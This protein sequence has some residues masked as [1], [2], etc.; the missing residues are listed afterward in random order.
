LWSRADYGENKAAEQEEA[1]ERG[2]TQREKDFDD[3]LVKIQVEAHRINDLTNRKA[4]TLAIKWIFAKLRSGAELSMSEEETEEEYVN[5]W[6]DEYFQND[7]DAYLRSLANDDGKLLATDYTIVDL[8][9]IGK[10][11]MSVIYDGTYSRTEPLP[12]QF[13]TLV[14]PVNAPPPPPWREDNVFH[15]TVEKRNRVCTYEDREARRKKSREY[16]PKIWVSCKRKFCLRESYNGAPGNTCCRTCE[17]W[18]HNDFLN[19][20]Y[21]TAVD[22]DWHGKSCRKRWSRDWEKQRDADYTV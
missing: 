1:H 20:R 11:L 8:Q 9:N 2:G 18:E 10:I 13:E 22:E 17:D 4:Y 12:S 16:E 3:H 15:L 14:D 6:D 5:R 21:P 7:A 19:H